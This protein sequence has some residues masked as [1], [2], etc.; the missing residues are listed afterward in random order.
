MNEDGE[1]E[2]RQLLEHRA[3]IELE[4]G[5]RSCQTVKRRWL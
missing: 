4:D 5:F 2:D 1:V 3:T